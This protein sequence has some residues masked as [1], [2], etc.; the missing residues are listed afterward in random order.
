[1]QLSTRLTCCILL[2]TAYL[3][4]GQ[5]NTTNQFPGCGT[6]E[7]IEYLRARGLMPGQNQR[8]PGTNP[9]ALMPPDIRCDVEG[10]IP[11]VVHIIHLGEPVGTGSN[12]SDAQVQQAI[13]GLNDAWANI[14]GNGTPLGLTFQLATRDP[15]GNTT[16]GITRTNGS[17]VAGY[18]ANGLSHSGSMGASENDIK[19]LVRWNQTNYYNIWVVYN[20]NGSA[21]GYAYYPQTNTFPNDGT[22]LEV[23]Y[24]TYTATVLAHELGHAFNL[25]HTFAGDAAGCPANADCT[26]DGDGVCDTPPHRQADCGATNPCPGGGTWNN[27]RFNIMSYCSGDRFTAGQRDRVQIALRTTSRKTLAQSSSLVPVNNLREAAVTAL[28]YPSSILCSATFQPIVTVRNYGTNAITNLTFE[29]Y[30]DNVLSSQFTI[31]TAIAPNLAANVEL[32]QANTLTGVHDLKIKLV[33][34]NGLMDETNLTDNQ[35]CTTVQRIDAVPEICLSFESAQVPAQIITSDQA[36]L[37][38][39]DV[40]GVCASQENTCLKIDGSASTQSTCTFL[41]GPIDLTG[42]ANPKLNFDIAR[43]KDYF[44]NLFASAT[45]QVSPDCGK[46]FNTVY[47]KNDAQATCPTPPATASTPLPLN[48]LGNAPGGPI[49]SLVPTACIQWRSESIDLSAYS[50]QTVV[51]RFEVR[52]D[53]PNRLNNVLY[54]DNICL[55]SCGNSAAN[56][57][58]TEPAAVTNI[59]FGGATTL[60]MSVS[61]PLAGVSYTWLN[62]PTPTGALSHVGNTNSFNTG[63]FLPIATYYYRGVAFKNGCADTTR[64]LTVIVNPDQVVSGNPTNVSFCIG[65]PRPISGNFNLGTSTTTY[66]WE[67]SAAVAG[68]W[69]A[70][71]GATSNTLLP[72]SNIGTT[73]YRLSFIGTAP[74][75]PT[76]FTNAAGVSVDPALT[77]AT[78]PQPLAGCVGGSGMLSV[79]VTGSVPFYRWQRATN[80]NGPFT[81]VAGATQSTYSPG[82][83][84]SGVIYYRVTLT[85]PTAFCRDTSVVVP[86]TISGNQTITTQPVN[87]SGCAGATNALSVAAAGGVAPLTYQWQ[88]ASD[89]I[90]P[91]NDVNGAINA[92]YSPGVAGNGMFYRVIVKSPGSGCLDIASN[93]FVSYNIDSPV[94]ISTPPQNLTQCTGGT[95]A[96][97]VTGTGSALIDYQW[98]TGSSLAGPWTNTGANQDNITPPSSATGTR[99]YRVILSSGA[100]LCKDTS[101]VASVNTV[102]GPAIT[103]QPAGYSACQTGN[104]PLTVSASGGTGTLNY[105]WQAAATGAGPWNNISGANVNTY[106]PGMS[107][108]SQFFRVLVAS[109]G[110]SCADAVSNPVNIVV[111]PAVS[112]SAEPQST[113]QC[114][115]G[116]QSFSTTGMGTGT[117]QYQWQSAAAANGPFN[118]LTATQNNYTPPGT[119]PGSN[120]YRLILR[121][122]NGLCRDTSVVVAANIIADPVIATQPAGAV[123]CGVAATNLNVVATGGIGT[124]TYQWQSAANAGGPFADINGATTANHDPGTGVGMYYRVIVKSPGTGCTDATSNATLVNAENPV[125]ISTEPQNINQ[126]VGGTQALTVAAAGSGLRYQWQSAGNAN[127]PWSDVGT[128]QNNHVPAAN[129]AGV[130]FFRAIVRSPGGFCQD[131]SAVVNATIAAAP[132]INTQPTGYTTCQG[133]VTPLTVAA[134]GGIG[135]L[136]YQWQSAAVAGGPWN[137]V[138]GAT[139]TTFTP[140]SNAPGSLFYRAVASSAGTACAAATSNPVNIVL[141]P[142]VTASAAT[143]NITQCVGGTQSITANGTSTGP[144]FYQWQEANA[145]TGPFTNISNAQNTYTPSN[146]VAGTTYYRSIIRSANGVCE[147]TTALLTSMIVADPVI[148]TQP[149]GSSGCGVANTNL[150]VAASGGIG[151]L[152]Y[153][154]QS[155]TAAAGPF[156]NIGGG[157][158][159]AYNPGAGGNGLFFRV[160]IQSAGAGCSDAVSNVTST[161]SDN[162]VNVST[163]P[164]AITQCVGGTQTFTVAGTGSSNLNYQWQSA[165]AAAGPWS[166]VG[167]NQNSFAPPAAT[168]GAAFYRA[169]IRSPGGFCKD[170]S[171]VAMATTAAAQTITAQ[172]AGYTTCQGNS[173]PLTVAAT[174]G[175]GTLGYQWQAAAAASGPWNNLNG[176]TASTFNP[177]TSTNAQFFRV[178]VSSSNPGCPAAISAVASVITDPSV[179]IVAEPQSIAQC[180]GGTLNLLATGSSTGTLQYQWQEAAASNGPFNNITA[181][182]QS[183]FTPS[184][185]TAGLRYYR[186]ILSST[187]GLCRDTSAVATSSVIAG[188]VIVTH[189]ANVTG[190]A[191]TTTGGLSVSVTGGIGT[192]NYQWQS[193]TAVGGPFV[194]VNGA[195]AAAYNPGAAGN[196]LFYRVVVR[197]SGSGCAD[198]NSNVANVN[199]DAPVSISAEPQ[200]L[201]Q[202]VGGSQSLSVTATGTGTLNYQ[203]QEANALAGPFS[204]IATATQSSFTPSGA[205]AGLRYYRLILSSTNGLCRDTSAVATS[206]VIAGPVIVTQPANVTGCANTTT[207]GLSV[208]AT[209]GIG[210]L[211]YQWQSA[212]AV[213]GPFANVNGATAATYNPGAAGN[214]LFY[215]VVV[216]SSGSGCADVNS[217]V[218]N[219]NTDAPVSISAEPQ[220]LTQ[221]V[222]GTQSLNVTATGG[223]LNYQWQSAA[224]AT[225]PWS[226]TGTNQSTVTPSAAA[227]GNTFYR[228]VVSSANGFC[229]DTSASVAANV[230]ADPVISTQPKDFSGCFSGSV[231]LNV[232]ANGGAGILTY[233]WQSSTATAGPWANVN[234]ATNATYSVAP[235]TGTTYYRAIVRASGSG[236][237]VVNSN[238]ANI[239][240]DQLLSI[241]AEPK[242]ISQCVGGTGN[243]TVAATS[244]GAILYQWQSATNATGPFANVVGATNSLTPLSSAAGVT[245]YRSILSSPNGLCKDTT[246]VAAATVAN[247]H[248]ISTQP[249]DFNACAGGAAA[250]LTIAASGGVAPLQY[251]WQS[252]AAAAGP[253]S[254]VAGATATNFNPPAGNGAVF[255]R[256]VVSSTGAGCTAVNSNPANVLIEAPVSIVAEPQPLFQCVGGT[257]T[258]N[259]TGIGS[260]ALN[261]QWQQSGSPTGPFVNVGTSQNNI[262]P[263]SANAGVQY[264]R[265]MITSPGG[266]CRDTSKVAAATITANLAI[267]TQPQGLEGCVGGQLTLNSAVSGGIA[268]TLQWQS[269]AAAAGPWNNI[270]GANQ[271]NYAPSLL[272]SGTTYYRMVANSAGSGCV[273]ANSA[274]ATVLLHPKVA[275]GTQPQSI[276]QCVGG[277]TALVVTATGGTTLAYQ[278]QVSNNGQSWQNISGATATSYVPVSSKNLTRRYRVLVRDA[279]AGCGADS[280]SAAVVVVNTDFQVKDT[281][282]VCNVVNGSSTARINFNSLILRGD[283]NS[284]WVSL[285]TIAPAGAW[286][287]KDFTAFTPGRLYRFVATTTNAVAPCI[288]VADTLVVRVK[289]CCPSVCTNPP[290]AAFCNSGGQP[291]NLSTLPCAGT[292][293]GSWTLT[294]GPG[295]SSPTSLAT[296]LF[297]PNGRAPG[298]YTVRYALSRSLP[299]VCA[300]V[301]DETITV[302]KAPEAGTLVVP[303]L[304]FCDNKDTLMVLANLISGED[305]NGIWSETSAQVSAPGAFAV[306]TGTLRTTPLLKGAYSFK[307]TVPAVNGC[308]ADAVTL[309]V[310]VA[311]TPKVKA[312]ADALLTCDDPEALVGDPNQN[313]PAGVRFEWVELLKNNAIPNKTAP[314]LTITEPGLYRLMA[315][316]TVSGCFAADSVRVT[317]AQN[318]ITDLKTDFT[319]PRCFG[320]NNGAIKVVDITGGTAPFQYLLNGVA[321]NSNNFTRLKAGIYTLRVQDRDGCFTER[322]ITLEEPPLVRFRF[323][324]DTTVFCGE[325]L[326]L[327][328]IPGL[329]SSLVAAVRWFSNRMP[330]DSANN[331]TLLV[332][333]EQNIVYEV[334]LADK[335]GCSST[336][337]V[338]IKVNEE[339]PVYAPNI[340]APESGGANSIFKVFG[341]ERVKLIRSFQVF[342]RGG[343]LV[344]EQTNADPAANFGWDG[345]FRGRPAPSGVYVFHA[346]V[347]YCTGKVRAVAGSVTLVR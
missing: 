219:V 107:A 203:W 145:P 318:Y 187:N 207:G 325:P 180:V 337:N 143:A 32:N 229:K 27:S 68:P 86:V 98:Q 246:T 47:Y 38:M 329:D 223:T 166:D 152:T 209:G 20:I 211:N 267:A 324:A 198:V 344:H 224:N 141:D 308:P 69:V 177:G 274:P 276:N 162:P 96:L 317:A 48:T 284:T 217:N 77:L 35:I 59:C 53:V 346:T 193:A 74:G 57:I 111:D 334:V 316:D 279:N 266:L 332:K 188:P 21:A 2:V 78:E 123:G 124:L 315:I 186:L 255:Y 9:T 131:T 6:D 159:S 326:L 157:T 191:N 174:G 199:T 42:N 214:G 277:N 8:G 43:A 220:A 104:T 136:T 314:A 172:P 34:I 168:V 154:W 108:G 85:S 82:F 309:Q 148:T 306:A 61:T 293:P 239:T 290:T 11:L 291:L 244:T 194:N 342:D 94:T 142:A 181:A 101:A 247:N 263:P 52:F 210:A 144:I 138:G 122:A 245:Y 87:V 313:Q 322:S 80:A 110:S 232:A 230:V 119:A 71:P 93:N 56:L 300:A 328:A 190:C 158:T 234:G 58:A 72:P 295:I 272:S 163:D 256:T 269:A 105:Q 179:S 83:F 183:S 218:A 248:A 251:Q 341:N 171:A 4:T 126:C 84:P 25:A 262:A 261:Y 216:R 301:S 100:A 134:S 339:L 137:N 103:T 113:T 252:A 327:R 139:A 249:A 178:L 164:Q 227:T 192:L 19:N 343:N 5:N 338:R 65:N 54:F 288:N 153:Q 81:N 29:I 75:C 176:A 99:Y 189:P 45:I 36:L 270:P 102:A 44:C 265:L 33:A 304:A 167:T 335:N 88:S 197:S 109:G 307:Y 13:D 331:L 302:A 213:G 333:P 116:T 310:Q 22:V 89:I 127:G 14:S 165:S 149:I 305:A 253:W 92:T 233:Q 7:N 31:N 184:G 130:S 147:D 170:T 260:P 24:M 289:N 231:N 115:G 155:A 311:V 106:N 208:S 222:G 97:S 345:V 3:L 238:P 49:G 30:I 215:R 173:N 18:S 151:S 51:L 257:A 118:D 160:L 95:G 226:N 235:T 294:T 321:K 254:N 60:A 55:K 336:D 28:I 150:S 286:N 268:P 66:Q 12:I 278:W 296:S 63:P 41:L 135:A 40:T 347:E 225:G 303:T 250:Q 62:A 146:T 340:F 91:Y 275:I 202:C 206:S 204:N 200:P 120:Y 212:T 128:N 46:T 292:E 10:G 70:I 241:T 299:A 240:L 297:D 39:Q 121:S 319:D 258:L 79:G 271:P 312:G 195:T 236:C 132:A 17:T 205:T 125:S 15:N 237:D 1:M 114:T 201:T 298:A 16:N 169:I 264:Y 259:A 133:A 67:S 242:S 26:V 196:G 23:A 76:I 221:C 156:A 112:I 175:I 140:P 330:I 273:S 50:G 287:A 282:E 90:G 243:L 283:P 117:L 37:K 161:N 281:V 280:S 64:L 73:F 129:T 320:D 323:N 182:T 285:D 228:T 185:A